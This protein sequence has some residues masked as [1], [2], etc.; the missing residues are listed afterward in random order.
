LAITAL[1]QDSVIRPSDDE[2]DRI[3]AGARKHA[4]NYST[5]LPNFLCVEMT[6]RAV[7]ATGNGKWR[8]KD[9]FG[10][11]LRFA[12][13]RETRTTLEV[14][15]RPSRAKRDD[16]NGPISLGEFGHL[17]NLVFQPSSKAEFHWKETDALANGTVQV[18]EYRVDHKNDNMVL[19]D[20]KGEV[21]SGFHG[22]AY[23]DSSTMGIRRITMEADDLPPDFSI[24]EASI[25][26]D[27]DYVAIG[28][29]E[30]LMPVRG[31]IRLKR[32]RHEADLNQIVFQDYRRYASQTKIVT[33]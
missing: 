24:H 16:M 8:R 1:P 17:V 4:V 10:E 15:G 5:K 27:Y 28:A 14:D 26:V 30:Y 9:S 23:I 33:H 25:A 18:F 20:S 29:H 7:D 31:T 32:G 22:L 2:L 13:N 6:D 19:S 3:I 21:S 12:D 11:L